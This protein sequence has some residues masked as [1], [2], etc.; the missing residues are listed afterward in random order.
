MKVPSLWSGQDLTPDPFK[1]LRREMEDMV[2]N[3]GHNLPALSVGAGAPAINVAETD[4][5]LEV[6]AELPGVEEKDIKVSVEGNRLVISGEKKH[7]EKRDEKDWHV[8]E[9][10]FGSF[11]RSMSLPFSP[12]DDAISAHLDKGVLHVSVKKPGEAVKNV[13]TVQ[14]KTGAPPQAGSAPQAG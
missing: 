7:E 12:A 6:T 1:S 11:Y 10:S 5:A 8:E 2:R 13:K 4:G 9:R 3:F 14:I